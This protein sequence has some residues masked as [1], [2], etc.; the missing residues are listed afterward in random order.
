M[1]EDHVDSLPENIDDKY[2]SG[3]GAAA[4]LEK[5]DGKENKKETLQQIKRK[6]SQTRKGRAKKKL[7]ERERIEGWSDNDDYYDDVDEL[8]DDNMDDDMEDDETMDDDVLSEKGLND[9]ETDSIDSW[10]MTEKPLDE[11]ED[12]DDED[13]DDELKEQ[14]DLQEEI[15]QLKGRYENSAIFSGAFKLM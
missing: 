8:Y 13:D 3:T 4:H 9:E 10:K 7:I 5:V 6:K 1:R 14:E 2:D 15:K 11:S 12:F